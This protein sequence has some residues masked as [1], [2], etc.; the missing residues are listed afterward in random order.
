MECIVATRCDIIRG[1]L[2]EH[3]V[4]KWCGVDPFVDIYAIAADIDRDLKMLTTHV[5]GRDYLDKYNGMK[6]MTAV[7]K[8][9]ATLGDVPGL[10]WCLD[11]LESESVNR[12]ERTYNR[13]VYKSMYP[14]W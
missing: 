10:Y 6:I 12:L 11:Q 9:R 1:L 14:A 3:D 7:L 4:F 2:N 8:R 13:S 5:W